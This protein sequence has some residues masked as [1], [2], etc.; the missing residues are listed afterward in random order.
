MRWFR[1]YNDVVALI[2]SSYRVNAGWGMHCPAVNHS[3]VLHAVGMRPKHTMGCVK[4]IRGLLAYSLRLA[5][6]SRKLMQR[7]KY[8]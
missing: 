8:I 5:Q 4:A 1:D 3:W 2:E 6:I 7:K